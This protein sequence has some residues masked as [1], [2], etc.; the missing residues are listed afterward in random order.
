[1]EALIHFG[2][3][4]DHEPFHLAKNAARV[5]LHVEEIAKAAI[6]T[7]LHCLRM[8]NQHSEHLLLATLRRLLPS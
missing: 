5:E 1:M 3:P 4:T 7:Q 2:R 8:P 6:V